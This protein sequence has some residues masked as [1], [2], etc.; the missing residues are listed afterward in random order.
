MYHIGNMAPSN[1][2]TGNIF[3]KNDDFTVNKIDFREIN[4]IA[5]IE[6]INREQEQILDRKNVDEEKLNMVIRL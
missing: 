3:V 1:Q 4:V 5:E 2:K 6:E